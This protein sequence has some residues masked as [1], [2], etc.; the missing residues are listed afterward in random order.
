VHYT[1]IRNTQSSAPEDGRDHC[2]KHVELIGII[3]KPLL[4]H[5]IGV[6]I[7]YGNDEWSNKYQKKNSF[8]V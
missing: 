1:I 8:F 2:P 6:Y 7:I 4:L 5:L 3:N